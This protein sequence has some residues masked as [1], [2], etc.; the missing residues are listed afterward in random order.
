MTEK[1]LATHDLILAA[2]DV[3]DAWDRGK[4]V[5]PALIKKLRRKADSA[6]CEELREG[7]ED[8]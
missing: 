5:D 3:C 4:G 8:D 2:H 1:E 7:N 6:L